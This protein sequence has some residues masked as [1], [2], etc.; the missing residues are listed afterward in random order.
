[1]FSS[2]FSLRL[3]LNAILL[4]HYSRY[5]LFITSRLNLYLYLIF[6]HTLDNNFTW[7]WSHSMWHMFP[8]SHIISPRTSLPI[9]VA[10]PLYAPTISTPAAQYTRVQTF[11]LIAF[12][13]GRR[14]PLIY[15]ERCVNFLSSISI[16]FGKTIYSLQKVREKP[17]MCDK[18]Q[19]RTDNKPM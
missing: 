5:Y 11:S 14:K 16:L 17:R 12:K 19:I 13:Y 3:F 18:W 4:T 15:S 9:H 10:K 2:K 1:M 6:L 7:R 8:Y